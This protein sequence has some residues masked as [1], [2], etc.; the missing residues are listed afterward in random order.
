MKYSVSSYSYSQLVGKK[1]YTEIELI[2]LAKEQGFD[3]IEFACINPPENESKSDYAIRLKN[4]AQRV[5]IEIVSYTIGAD[6]LGGSG[7][8]LNA[9][10]ERL[11]GEVDIAQLLGVK[12]MRHDT[13]Y[14]MD[15][16]T[17]SQR[18]FND[19][20]PRIVEGCRAVT[21]YAKTKGIRT[22]TENHGLFCQDSERVERI[23]NGVADDNFGWLADVGNF[24]CA[25]E[26][27][28]TAVGRLAP[29][30]FHVHCK[31]FHF[32]SG[33]GAVP[34]NGFFKTRGGNFLRGAIIG[35]GD[36]PVLQCM[37]ILND[38]GYEGFYTVEFEG[39]ED[40]KTG[41]AYG[42]NTLKYYST[43]L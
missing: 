31:D 34:Q 26:N 22:M 24:M 17:R 1:L 32:K 35:H 9:E 28:V 11:K 12:L 15:K 13:A 2:A 19:I 29:Y 10:I 20:L 5:G 25:D 8:D 3:G 30:V 6:F 33:S 36:V 23:I 39:M 21:Q 16:E 41:V 18:G 7:G 37:R 42:L 43:L 40:A 4:E 14:G 38:A 27:P